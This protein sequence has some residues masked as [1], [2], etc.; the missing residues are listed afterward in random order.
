[1]TTCGHIG[2]MGKQG[3]M[4]KKTDNPSCKRW[5]RNLIQVL[6]LA[7]IAATGASADETAPPPSH[8][9]VKIKR[10]LPHDPKAFTQG[11][12]VIK[13]VFYESTGTYGQSTL[14]EVDVESGKVKRM[15]SLPANLFG[16]GLTIWKN[17]LI[18]LTWQSFQGRIYDAKSLKFLARFPYHTEGWGLTQDGKHLIS[19]DG[20]ATLYFLDPESLA[21]VRSIEVKDNGNAV[22]NLNEL[23]YIN[24]KI[25][26]NIFQS[27]RIAVIDPDS[28]R[29]KAW[30]DCA[31]LVS[32]HH[33]SDMESVLNGIAFDADSGRI[34]MTGKRWNAVYEIELNPVLK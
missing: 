7:A 11:L 26:A 12:I 22:Y 4:A 19:S 29:V 18:Q 20:T 25:W 33:S 32:R 21:P 30:I 23:E 17:R 34:Y 24:G 27:D 16:E 28:G 31:D 5:R 8:H 3:T 14:R 9:H 15:V 13:G 10:L 6:I 1:M 2:M